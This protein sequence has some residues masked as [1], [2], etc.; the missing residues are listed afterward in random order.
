[1]KPMFA[2]FAAGT[3]V[4]LGILIAVLGFLA[5]GSMP[6]VIVGLVAVFAGGLLGL[7]DRRVAH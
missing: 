1:M 7:L 6:F 3:L 5:G 2:T 4:V